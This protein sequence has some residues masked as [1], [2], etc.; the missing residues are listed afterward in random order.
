[1]VHADPSARHFEGHLPEMSGL[2][3]FQDVFTPGSAPTHQIRRFDQDRAWALITTGA[4]R[5]TI[6]H[7]FGR[8]R[9][10]RRRGRLGRRESHL[11]GCT[12]FGDVAQQ[13]RPTALFTQPRLV[14]RRVAMEARVTLF[15]VAT[16]FDSLS[17]YTC[18][19]VCHVLRY[20]QYGVVPTECHSCA[21]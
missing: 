11:G 21:D 2:E 12:R 19:C 8:G 13:R 10:L 20:Q 17:G 14:T 4:A 16:Q 7:L 3:L 15:E 1:V 5:Q 6:E 9:S 18:A